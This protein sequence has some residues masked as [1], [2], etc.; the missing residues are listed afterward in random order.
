MLNFQ[1]LFKRVSATIVFLLWAGSFGLSFAEGSDEP[2]VKRERKFTG[3]ALYGFMNGGSDL[4]LEYGFKELRAIEVVYKDEDYSIEIYSMPTPEDA[5]GIY[6]LHT[7]SSVVSDTIGRFDCHS[8]NQLQT[9]VGSC[10]ISIVYEKSC[11]GVKPGAVELL[12]LYT[13]N[14]DK[15]PV[16]IPE[17]VSGIAPPASGVLKYLKGPLAIM[18]SF[19]E[20]DSIVSEID[21]YRIWVNRELS[22]GR[23]VATLFFDNQKVPDLLKERVSATKIIASG[24]DFFV[25]EF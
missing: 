14:V 9:V 16:K 12:R 17:I 6:S 15:T 18:N 4:Y 3:S 22:T 8:K 2:V 20:L 21:D 23:R 11:D 7:F 24:K 13:Q 5:F 19:G 10:Y 1:Q 25:F